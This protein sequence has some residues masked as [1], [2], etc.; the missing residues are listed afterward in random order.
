MS[1]GW[2]TNADQ[3]GPIYVEKE[4]RAKR[5]GITMTRTEKGSHQFP[6]L[7]PRRNKA[8]VEI[9]NAACMGSKALFVD[10]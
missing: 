7:L 5:A 8:A 2:C 4:P 10:N 6:E 3:L 1:R 9:A